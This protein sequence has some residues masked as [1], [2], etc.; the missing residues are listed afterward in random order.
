MNEFTFCGYTHKELVNGN[1]HK[2]V[3]KLKD[4]Y[5]QEGEIYVDEFGDICIRG[6]MLGCRYDWLIFNTRLHGQSSLYVN[7]ENIFE[8]LCIVKK[9]AEDWEFKIIKKADKSYAVDAVDSK[10]G[11]ILRNLFN[12]KKDNGITVFPCADFTKYGEYKESKRAFDKDGHF[13]VN[14]L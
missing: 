1:G 11:E 5:V 8:Y 7:S 4:S 2:V 10:S 13:K 14:I 6:I 12:F 3:F 9:E